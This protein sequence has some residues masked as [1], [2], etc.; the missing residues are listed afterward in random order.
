ME[1]IIKEVDDAFKSDPQI[2]EVGFVFSVPDNKNVV[3]AEHKLGILATNL[4][5]L[6]TFALTELKE[7]IRR[8]SLL[9]EEQKCCGDDKELCSV[10]ESKS[11]IILLIQPNMSLA[12]NV[13]KQVIVGKLEQI[14]RQQN[15]S[16]SLQQTLIV[17][18][19]EVQL[20][21]VLL[22]KSPKSPILWQHRRW[23]LSM[24]LQ[25]SDLQQDPLVAVST[26]L[27]FHRDMKSVNVSASYFLK[28]DAENL[29][30]ELSLAGRL[31]D[32][33]TKNYYAWMHRNWLLRF[34]APVSVASGDLLTNE[35][36]WLWEWCR[37]H[38]SEFCAMNHL[39]HALRLQLGRLMS[40]CS[41]ETDPLAN[42]PPQAIVVSS[43]SSS[44][45]DTLS[46]SSIRTAAQAHKVHEFLFHCIASSMYLI[47]QRPGHLSLWY[48]RE[49][50]LD[51]LKEYLNLLIRCCKTDE[52]EHEW[53]ARTLSVHGMELCCTH[54]ITALTY[55]WPSDSVPTGALDQLT[56]QLGNS[57]STTSL[58][59]PE[60]GLLLHCDDPAQS[61][62][63]EGCNWRNLS[64]S[65]QAE[66]GGT[67]YRDR[68]AQT[69]CTYLEHL[70][71]V[72]VGLDH[73]AEA[74]IE[75]E[76]PPDKAGRR[77][78]GVELECRLLE[79]VMHLAVSESLL[80]ASC[81][82]E[83]SVP[84]CEPVGVS[85][86]CVLKC[87]EKCTCWLPNMAPSVRSKP[88]PVIDSPLSEGAD[89][90]HDLKKPQSDQAKTYLAKFFL[91]F[92]LPLS[93]QT[94]SI[95]PVLRPSPDSVN[96]AGTG[97][98]CLVG[99]RNQFGTVEIAQSAVILWMR[100]LT[101]V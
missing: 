38:P 61:N 36:F 13:R 67:S 94:E 74:I 77:R 87:E 84:L 35:I 48:F 11:R 3:L 10:L 75:K 93:K 9:E 58:P 15:P 23:C 63:L 29:A 47:I 16:S 30:R 42:A 2:D 78:R 76:S 50:V 27:Q 45:A 98:D 70:S 31:G 100:F 92:M 60:F 43:S 5:S 97:N 55:Q 95:S 57:N 41:R 82:C 14:V 56:S 85:R 88:K 44:I 39:R 73:V 68:A 101:A 62:S 99:N 18:E 96:N 20:L 7:T 25:C 33:H 59:N 81:H 19:N 49:A 65:G 24:L 53:K 54:L 89:I 83:A 32:L 71:C 79:S 22:L 1:D 91:R 17:L 86:R 34:M 37:Q 4:K 12:L 80:A 69:P 90:W 51:L 21:S 8:V 64:S 52:H 6:Y 28:H 66:G 40:D 46:L 26:L 72:F